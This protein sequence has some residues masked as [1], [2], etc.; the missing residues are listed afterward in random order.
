MGGRQVSQGTDDGL[1][2]VEWSR[3]SPVDPRVPRKSYPFSDAC[4]AAVSFFAIFSRAPGHPVAQC[5]SLAAELPEGADRAPPGTAA[6]RFVNHHQQDPQGC[7]ERDGC[8][9]RALD[10]HISGRNR[11][12]EPGV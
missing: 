3:G 8:G 9:T 7:A 1:L 10:E 6:A 12:A 5:R 2:I 11:T 4:P